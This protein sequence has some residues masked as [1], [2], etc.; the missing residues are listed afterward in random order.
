MSTRSTPIFT[1]ASA[2]Q[3]TIYSFSS[4]PGEQMSNFDVPFETHH[5][6]LE[7]TPLLA[8][9]QQQHAPENKTAI[10]KEEM[11]KITLYTLP[12]LA[13]QLLEFSLVVVEVV[14]VGHISTSALGAA[15]LGSMTAS[16]TGYCTLH[17]LT[18]ALD[19]VLPSAFTS[20]QPHLVGLWAQPVVVFF[21][22]MATIWLNAESILLYIKQ[23]PEIAKLA[24]LYLRWLAFGLPAFGFNCIFRRYF[25]SQG[26][27][28]VQTQINLF[29][30]PV[31]ILLNY[32]LGQTA[33]EWWAWELL[34][35]AAS[36]LNPLSLAS[37]SI[38]L[39]SSSTTYQAVYA[40]SNATAI[41]IGNLLG[42]KNAKQASMAASASILIALI[43]SLMLSRDPEVI[44][45]V[46]SVIPLIALYQV[47]EGN[48][49]VTSGI[50]QAK[51][52]QDIGAAL[53][54]RTDWDYEAAKV[55]E[56][57]GEEDRLES[58]QTGNHV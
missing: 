41:R 39:T 55:A 33:A 9:G 57:I 20:S 17:G 14:S 51:G 58:P 34:A 47:V 49:A 18:S 27:F 53:N 45:L 1:V 6:A 56:R 4:S 36:F 38:L 23:D 11:R 40:L 25:Q 31:N 3:P 21:A 42:K 26:L 8:N 19:T 2:S 46:A 35:L 37:Q 29:V 7:S 12:A 5:H 54:I 48:A 24:A 13:S 30:A 15:S 22:L 10:L 28:A 43:I 50:L 44:S 16:V 52:Q 32:L